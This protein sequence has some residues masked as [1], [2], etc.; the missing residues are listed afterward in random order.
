[1]GE[2][3]SMNTS[4]KKTVGIVSPLL[5]SRRMNTVAG[6]ADTRLLIGTLKMIALNILHYKMDSA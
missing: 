5:V 4:R 3:V 6:E 1:M 2:L